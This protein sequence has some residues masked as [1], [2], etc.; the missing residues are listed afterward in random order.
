MRRGPRIKS[1]GILALKSLGKERRWWGWWGGAGSEPKKGEKNHPIVE[2]KEHNF[3]EENFN[4]KI[5]RS[6]WTKK[7]KASCSE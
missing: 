7:N 3:K 6:H 4:R 1:R 2:S 5:Y